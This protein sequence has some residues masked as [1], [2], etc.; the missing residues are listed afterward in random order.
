VQFIPNFEKS[1]HSCIVKVKYTNNGKLFEKNDTYV[2]L[3]VA[4]YG[5]FNM[6]DMIASIIGGNLKTI[7]NV[8]GYMSDDGAYKAFHFLN[9]HDL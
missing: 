1:G 6:T 4:D 7:N 5:K 9:Y 8:S 3:L 2:S